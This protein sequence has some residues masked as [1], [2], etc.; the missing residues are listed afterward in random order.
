MKTGGIMG[1]IHTNAEVKVRYLLQVTELT[2]ASGAYVWKLIVSPL[3]NC[4]SLF[5]CFGFL[6]L[7]QWSFVKRNWEVFIHN[8]IIVM[9]Y[10]SRINRYSKYKDMIW[11]VD[12]LI[13]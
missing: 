10:V 1:G 3:T 11:R 5:S 9:S 12:W 7:F 4:R 13:D 8:G 2:G 6:W